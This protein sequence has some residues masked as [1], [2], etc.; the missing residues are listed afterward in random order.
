M[1]PVRIGVIG[2]GAM[3]YAH[4]KNV[5]SLKETLL[6]CV[7]DNDGAAAKEKGEEFRVPYFTDYKKLAKSGLCDAVLV[8]IPHWFHPDVTIYA[9]KSGL[10]VICEKPVAVTVSDVDRM[11]A[12]ARRSRKKFAVMHQMRTE[13]FFRKAKEIMESGV[14]GRITRTLCIDPWYRTQAYYDS[15]VWRATWKGEGGG[16]L[17]NQAPHIID[18]FILLGGLPVKV[19]AKT[20]TRLHD[21]EV[22]DE[23][24][25][26][27]QYKNGA[28]GYYYTTTCETFGTFH[29]EI[30]GDTGKLV[31]NGKEKMTLYGYSEPVSVYTHKA[32]SMW[33]SLK[34]EEET[35][36]FKSNVT[37]GQTEMIRNFAAAISGKEKLFAEGKDGLNAVEF[38]NACILSGKK[39]KPVNIPVNRKEY[40]ALIE[41][42]KR[43][44]KPKKRVVIQRVTD[45]KFAK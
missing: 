20:R 39:R 21:I 29:M 3:G 37:T 8:V 4:C 2:L 18:L 22:E 12:A 13:P 32:G 15:N 6:T 40:D 34:V 24:A 25:A 36:E 35:F 28:W 23:V 44:S 7:C 26:A 1:K 16:V 19:D 45:P 41:K 14:L 42:L 9:F 11:I 17:I 43:T 10:H 33:A 38:I 31:I 27:L 5:R 30:A